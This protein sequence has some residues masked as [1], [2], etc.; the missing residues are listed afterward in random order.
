MNMK[1][2]KDDEQKKMEIRIKKKTILC[3]A[4]AVLAVLLMVMEGKTENSN[5][6]ETDMVLIEGGTYRMGGGDAPP[7]D[8][9]PLHNVTLDDFFIGKTEVTQAQWQDVMGT[10]PSLYKGKN[11]P[12]EQVDWYDAVEYCNRRS[13]KEGLTPCYTKEG[14]NIT[15]NFDAD[16]YRLPTEAEWEN[17]AGGGNKTRNLVY[18]GSNNVEEVAVYEG[19]SGYKPHPVAQMKPNELGIYDMSGNVWEWTWDRYHRDYYKTAPKVNPKG[20]ETGKLRSYR[21]GGACGPAK[22]QQIRCR[23]NQPPIFKRFDMGFRVARKIGGKVPTDMVVVEGGTVEIG[24]DVTENNRLPVHPVTVRAFKISKYEVTQEEWTR[25]MGYNPSGV[26]GAHCPVEAVSWYDAVRFCNRKSQN[27]GIAPAY[28]IEGQT[29]TCDFES[30]GYR[31][32]TEA[33]WEY[34]ARGG[35]RDSGK[36]YSGSD[37]VEEVAW[38]HGNSG[39]L[40]HPVGQKK[41]N[42]DNLYDMNGNVAEWCWDRYND[43]YYTRSPEKDPRGPI[44]GNY[45]VVRGGCF[46]HRAPAVQNTSRDYYDPHRTRG[47]LGIR[48]VKSIGKTNWKNQSEKTAKQKT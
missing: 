45:R 48:L 18:S 4:M 37:N 24:S 6:F 38:Y 10:N 17:A 27:E 42:S 22:Y 20:P 36:K 29:V 21:G 43:D 47:G 1:T 11:H 39:F 34:A 33:E 44:K 31:L 40:I 15:C 5:P 2:N 41:T 3:V 16:G 28:R 13:K 23:Y 7:A 30:E 26:K 14:E 8:N 32:P 25:I 46:I 9:Q 35:H 12:V 19:N